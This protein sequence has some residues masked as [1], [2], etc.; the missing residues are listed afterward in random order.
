MNAAGRAGPLDVIGQSHILVQRKLLD[1]S[2]F[3]RA[4]RDRG[5]S[6]HGGDLE[7]LHRARILVPIYTVR[8][9]QW[10]IN[11]R[12][13]RKSWSE[14]RGEPVWNVPKDGPDLG[15]DHER[16]LVRDGDSV[17]FRPY[18]SDRVQTEMGAIGRREHLY[19]HYQLL[20]LPIAA[21]ALPLLSLKPAARTPWQRLELRH[22]RAAAARQRELVALLSVLEP[23]YLPG[24]LGHRRSTLSEAEGEYERYVASYDPIAT[25]RL[26]GWTAGDLYEMATTLLYEASAR[27]PLDDWLDLVRLVHPD[28]W[29]R[30]KGDARLAVD[31]RVAAELI[32][33]FLENLQRLGAAP[34]FPD[35]PKR[36]PHALN[37]RIRRDRAELDDVLMSFGLSPYPAVVL[38]L[39]GA[40]EMVVA[41][42][43]MDCLG[44][45]QSESFI[46][47]VDSGGEGTEHGLLATYVALPKL[48]PREGDIASFARPP[49]RYFIAVDGDGKFKDPGALE[50]ERQ[51]WVG[52]LFHSLPKNLQTPA[53]RDDL[54]T[55]VVVETWAAGMDFER[56][57]FTDAELAAGLL[58]T[59]LAPPSTALADLE[60]MLAN[61]RANGG[62]I[63]ALWARWTRTPEKP[64][65]AL[66]LWPALRAKLERRIGD[67]TRLSE[68]PIARVLLRA[69]ELA[70]MTPRRHVVFR[71]G[72]DPTQPTDDQSEGA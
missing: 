9:P 43:V 50:R 17:R 59:G 72:P 20:T 51:R 65:L 24:F 46:R 61:Q 66:L 45:P 15:A 37:M 4:G 35:V 52:M 41:P 70:A 60:A 32:F 31:S 25:L 2:E 42:L 7:R 21:R 64:E 53:A 5:V 23:R 28:R 57:H 48:G 30:L 18:A 10:D 68:I 54:D 33:R 71:V 11:R 16:G 63:K 34:P 36:A 40:T 3:E 13:A 38:A 44:I 47:L 6:L 67:D 29:D 27:D 22:V 26:L 14:L 56:A 62:N 39:E 8:R 1:A 55:M 49:S 19:S 58:A 69:Y 12:V